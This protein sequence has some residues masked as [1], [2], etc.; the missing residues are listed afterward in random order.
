MN[1]KEIIHSTL[2]EKLKTLTDAHTVLVE[3]ALQVQ[4]HMESIKSTLRDLHLINPMEQ[5]RD[6]NFDTSPNDKI[7]KLERELETLYS[8]ARTGLS[9][10]EITNILNQMAESDSSSVTYDLLSIV[11]GIVG[12]VFEVTKTQFEAGTIVSTATTNNCSLEQLKDVVDSLGNIPGASKPCYK[13]LDGKHH[14]T[15]ELDLPEKVLIK[16]IVSVTQ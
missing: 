2:I 15:A 4:Q 12:K 13:L 10:S 9:L 6:H 16:V 11:A 14:I 3:T 7:T 1:A 8:V 5:T